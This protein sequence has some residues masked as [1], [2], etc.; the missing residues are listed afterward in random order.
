VDE[1]LKTDI[2]QIVK[3]YD[4]LSEELEWPDEMFGLMLSVHHLVQDY[5]QSVGAECQKC[6]IVTKKGAPL[7]TDGRY[8]CDDVQMCHIRVMNK[9]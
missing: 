5:K 3:Y 7:I 6:G 2:E 8:V 1:K 9:K 4:E